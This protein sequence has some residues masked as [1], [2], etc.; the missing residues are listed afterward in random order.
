MTFDPYQILGVDKTASTASVR[1]AYRSRAKKLHPDAGGSAEAFSRLSRAHLVLADPARR[2][3]FDADGVFDE[4]A[5]DNSLSKAVSICVGFFASMV[6]QHVRSGATDPLTVN[7]VALAREAFAKEIARFEANKRPIERA[8]KKLE[9]VEARLKSKRSAN[10]LLRSALKMQAAST[11][12]PLA[13][14][15]AQIAAYRDAI[16]LLDGYEFVPDRNL[17]FER[18]AAV[19]EGVNS[20]QARF[21]RGGAS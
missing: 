16:A 17:D 19:M 15:D 5:A 13:A 8:R 2:A 4:G 10:P 20:A 18:M 9:Q 14:I 11:A 1:A 3:R 12:Q 6:E 7:L 21:Y